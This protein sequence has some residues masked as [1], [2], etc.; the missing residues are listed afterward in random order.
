MKEKYPKISIV[1][2]SYNQ[3]DFLEE[4]ILSILNQNYPNLEYIIIDGGSTDGSVDVIRKYEDKLA[5][6]VSERD[7]GQYNGINKGFA[8]STGEI[9]AW[10]NSDD[11]LLPGALSAVASIFSTF[12][13][14]E[15]LTSNFPVHWNIY[16]QAVTC[17]NSGGFN[18][19][20]FFRGTNLPGCHWYARGWIQQESTFWRR[21]LWEKSGGHIKDSLNYAGD[22]E[23][24]ARFYKNTD[25]YAVNA[26][27]GGF[28]KYGDQ[29]TGLGMEHYLKEA[30]SCFLSDY[31]G[32]PYGK[33]NST[34]RKYVNFAIGDK[35]YF[36][37]L[38]PK[39][40]PKA[41]VNVGLT[42]PANM[43]VWTGDKWEMLTSYVI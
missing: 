10:L 14:I 39:I 4:T 9:M 11:K 34:I 12:S 29:K 36:L 30:K 18:R 37:Y 2:P 23:L 31:S 16:G 42:Y 21:S 22:F 24:W 6:W 20:S 35:L 32:R 15:W 3:A 38:C 28:R 17:G 5:Y 43:V 13:Q 25:L 33:I 19:A 40:I 26:L 27:I 7:Q 41:L 8:K 1:T